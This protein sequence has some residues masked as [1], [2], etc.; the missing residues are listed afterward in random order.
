MWHWEG[1][2]NEYKKH[3]KYMKRTNHI[4]KKTKENDFAG[5]VEGPASVNKK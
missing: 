2:Y 4:F 3:L 1:L 5:S